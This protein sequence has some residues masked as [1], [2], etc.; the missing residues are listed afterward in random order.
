MSCSIRKGSNSQAQEKAP[1]VGFEREDFEEQ[2]Y[3]P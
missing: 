2:Q 1:W 3:Q